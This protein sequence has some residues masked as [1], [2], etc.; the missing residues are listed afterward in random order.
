MQISSPVLA[1]VKASGLNVL[2]GYATSFQVSLPAGT[3]A[4]VSNTAQ[5]LGTVTVS[6]GLVVS[7]ANL[8]TGVSVTQVPCVQ[9]S[10]G[11]VVEDGADNCPAVANADQLDQDLDGFGDVCD[12]DLDGDGVPNA[13][14]LCPSI[15]DDQSDLDGDGLGDACDGDGDGE[16]DA[17]D[18]DVDGDGIANDVDLCPG[19]SLG[20]RTNAEGCGGIQLVALRC[21][22]SAFPNH[23]RYVS[24]VAR[25]SQAAVKDGLLTEEERARLVSQAAH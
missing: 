20:V 5:D 21:V 17:C 6:A 19:T 1:I 11:D 4:L 7:S 12:D 10:D 13:T 24:C 8:A 25:E 16:G 22:E 14:D 15:A 18:G 3:Y 23:G 9:D 2:R